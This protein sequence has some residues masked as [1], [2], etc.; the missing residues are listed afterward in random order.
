MLKS[1]QKTEI[2]VRVWKDAILGWTDQASFRTPA[3]EAAIQACE[4][5]LGQPVP[6]TLAGLLRESNGVEGVYGLGLI[7][8]VERIREDNLAF[9]TDAEFATLYMPFDP[10]FFFADAGNGDQFAFVM[11]DCRTDVFAWDH[12]SD[13]R[14]WVAPSLATY[15]DWWL[16]GRLRL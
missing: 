2:L 15:L 14:T 1:R 10:L 16:D 7:W 8:P 9:R 12:E 13:S 4:V 3:S 6:G 5:A 11:R